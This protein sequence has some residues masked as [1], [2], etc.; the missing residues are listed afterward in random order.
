LNL[1]LELLEE[2]MTK[3]RIGILTGGGDV[4][5]L[6]VAIKSVV[7][8]ASDDDAEVIGIRRGWGGF[9][10]YDFDD[11]T[12]HKRY[13]MPLDKL[14]C[15]TIDRTGGT[16]LHTS[17]TNPSAVRPIDVPEFLAKTNYGK[18]VKNDGTKDYTDYVLKVIDH[19]KL[20]S[21]I[22]IGG[23]DTL[24][25]SNHL[26]KAGVPLVAIPKDDG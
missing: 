17:R 1:N 16:F 25:Y 5:G 15:R 4:P 23:D 19:L 13:I 6:N 9:L 2:K 20:D 22:T 3:R 11:I 8:N 12:S 18:K 21:L 7:Y 10:N 24:C 14:N 26:F